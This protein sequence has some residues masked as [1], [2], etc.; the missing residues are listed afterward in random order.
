MHSQDLRME[1]MRGH[2]LAIR[3]FVLL[4]LRSGRF[5]KGSMAQAQAGLGECLTER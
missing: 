2:P 1:L 5:A 3:L 4:L